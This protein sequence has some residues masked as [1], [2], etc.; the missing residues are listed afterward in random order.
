[1]TAETSSTKFFDR[2][3]NWAVSLEAT[4]GTGIAFAVFATAAVLLTRP[5]S[6]E[7]LDAGTAAALL[8]GGSGHGEVAIAGYLIVFASIAL[9]WFIGT[10]RRRIGDREDKLFATV[11]LGS[12]LVLIALLLAAFAVL[13][14]PNVLAGMTDSGTAAASVPFAYSL[15]AELLT[16]VAPRVAAVFILS[17]TT[18]GRISGAFP[19]WLSAVNVVIALLLLIGSGLA[20]QIWWLFPAWT[21]LVGCEIMLHRHDTES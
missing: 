2:A 6:R 20:W 5:V 9:L 17:L 4:G 14:T 3:R 7:H 12:G 21:F 19:R 13:A 10:L 15:G 16:G 18:L 8:R 1:M 11:F